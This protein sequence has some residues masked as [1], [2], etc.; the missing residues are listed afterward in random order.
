MNPKLLAAKLA[1]VMLEVDGVAKTGYNSFHKYKFVEESAVSD[2]IRG[3]LAKRNVCVIPTIKDWKKEGDMAIVFMEFTIRD[4]DTGDFIVSSMIGEGVDKGDKAF[5]KAVT[6]ATK[7]WLLK[8]FL[9]PTNNDAEADTETDKRVTEKKPEQAGKKDAYTACLDVAKEFGVEQ[10]EVNNLLKT[11][12]KKTNPSQVT[13]SD[14]EKLTNLLKARGL[15][16][17]HLGKEGENV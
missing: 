6:M 14:V 3:A 2:A 16:D 4:G 11:V 8:T 9:M 15:V 12:F 17:K 10:P 13:A 5:P 7:Y 1:E